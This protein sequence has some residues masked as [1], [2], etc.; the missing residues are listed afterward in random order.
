MPVILH[1]KKVYKN[2]YVFGRKLSKGDKLGIH[3]KAQEYA[4]RLIELGIESALRPKNEKL[5]YIKALRLKTETLK[6]IIRSE[7]EL[8]II[9]EKQYLI[10]TEDLQNISMMTNGW[11]KSIETQTPP[12]AG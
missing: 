1:A 3:S 2:I 11:I 9:S 7:Y 12:K 6:H 8:K 4:L 5:E 10:I